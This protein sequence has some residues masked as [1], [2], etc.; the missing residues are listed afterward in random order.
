MEFKIKKQV[1][2]E[3]GKKIKIVIVG[4]GGIGAHTA[5]RAT[6]L[7]SLCKDKDI[8]LL[9]CDGD[10]VE[11]K[12]LNRQVFIEN[13]IDSNKAYVTAMRCSAAYHCDIEISDKYIISKEDILNFMDFGYFPVI[14]GCSD[15]LKLRY[16]ISQTLAS[17]EMPSG[18][19]I[20]AGNDEN[21][22][23]I[24]FTYK[25]NGEYLTPDYFDIFKNAKEKALNSKLV[26]EMSCAEHMISA[27]QTMFANMFAALGILSYLDA[28][29]NDK[30]IKD[31]AKYFNSS[32]FISY[33]EDI[34]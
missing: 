20:D 10:K 33:T 32:R 4:L 18:V 24:V 14:L 2:V 29:I 9:F 23:Q 16:I 15:S 22:G 17:N 30:P 12:N 11:Q 19:Y 13:D 26:T 28:I 31:G 3:T 34:Q 25:K 6:Q 8:K 5:Y 1:K 7:I 27:P 21:S